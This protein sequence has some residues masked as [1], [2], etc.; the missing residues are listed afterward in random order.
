MIFYNFEKYSMDSFFLNNSLSITPHFKHKRMNI[1]PLLLLF[2]VIAITEIYAEITNNIQLIY[3]IKPLLLISLSLFYYQSIRL[4]KNQFSTMIFFGLTFSIG[5]DTFL[6]FQGSQFFI[7]GLGCF[8]ITHIFYTIAFLNFKKNKLGLLAS[9]KWLIIPF[10]L[11]LAMLLSYLWP[12]LNDMKVPVL[13]YATV[14]CLMAITAINLKTKLPSNIFYILFLGIMLF[15]FS[16]TIIALNKFKS[17]VLEIPYSRIIIMSTYII[18]QLLIALST[19]K[20]NELQ[21]KNT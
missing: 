16:D 15:M 5:G 11:Y 4:E 21:A 12:D 13:I 18:A 8:L 19:I 14:I 10:L 20:A 7:A 6:M 2:G 17:D 1:K 3:I 9:K